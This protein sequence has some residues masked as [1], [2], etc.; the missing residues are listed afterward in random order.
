V[1]LE[2]DRLVKEVILTPVETCEFGTPIASVL[3]ANGTICI[4]RDYKVT[5][6]PYLKTNRY[7]LPRI[8]DLFSNISGIIWPKIDLSQAYTQLLVEE[9]SKKILTLSTHQ[10]LYVRNRLMYKIASVPGIFQREG[11]CI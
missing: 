10:G 8:E 4:C 3:K 2:L 7:Q 6:N 9:N 5:I 11:K 1:A